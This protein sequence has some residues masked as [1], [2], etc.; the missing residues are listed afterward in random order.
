MCVCVSACLPPELLIRVMTLRERD[1][2]QPGGECTGTRTH[3][4]QAALS[5]VCVCARALCSPPRIVLPAST[6]GVHAKCA[7]TECCGTGE[8]AANR[9]RFPCT[10]EMNTLQR[11]SFW[12]RLFLAA[13]YVLESAERY[14][15]RALRCSTLVQRHLCKS[16]PHALKFSRSF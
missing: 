12:R 3:Y 7:S 11:T 14:P 16:Y 15:A 10:A 8:Q 6:R 13:W 5:P 2:G 9:T 4:V 1:C